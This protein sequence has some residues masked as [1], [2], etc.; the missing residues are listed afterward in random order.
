MVSNDLWFGLYVVSNGLAP[1][2]G[3]SCCIRS[4]AQETCCCHQEFLVL[5]RGPCQLPVSW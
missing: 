2:H 5:S 1:W 3:S 4:T